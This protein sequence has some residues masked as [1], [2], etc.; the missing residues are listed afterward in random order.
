[1][2]KRKV[3]NNNNKNQ[4]SCSSHPT[5]PSQC[6]HV[7]LQMPPQPRSQFHQLH[8]RLVLHRWIPLKM[9][10]LHKGLPSL[11]LPH[12][13]D[14]ITHPSDEA[15]IL[16]V[17][18]LHALL[19][20]LYAH[21]LHSPHSHLKPLPLPPQPLP[22]VHQHRPAN[23]YKFDGVFSLNLHQRQSAPPPPRVPMEQAEAALEVVMDFE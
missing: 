14:V 2:K 23:V 21:L 12:H 11:L 6:P 3:N 1:M 15:L 20:P 7:Q 19:T 9:T 22:S 16:H 8:H 13:R 17:C 4:N 5:R 10:S 18:S